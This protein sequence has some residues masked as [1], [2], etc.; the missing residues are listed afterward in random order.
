MTIQLLP[1]SEWPKLE[2]IFRQ[3]W[4][5]CLPHPDHGGIIAEL[6][7]EELIAFCM[8]ESLIR[9][10]NFYTAPN[11]RGNGSVRRLISK[12]QEVAPRS[13]RSFIALADEPR[14]AALF[15]SLGM[16]EVGMA[17]RKDFFEGGTR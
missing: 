8:T 17:F 16:R 15:R 11:H 13:G 14:Y 12:M 3:E 9:V 10:G 1:P 4:G 2:A 7:D 6:E 5:A